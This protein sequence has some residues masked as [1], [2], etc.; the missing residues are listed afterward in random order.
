MDTSQNQA[1]GETTPPRTDEAFQDDIIGKCL[2]V[3]LRAAS[4]EQVT[5]LGEAMSLSLYFHQ[6]VS[7]VLARIERID[8]FALPALQD[9]LQAR[10]GAAFDVPR[11]TFRVGHREP[12]INAQPVGAHLTE[13]VYGQM[14]LLE[15]A[16][17]NFTLAE[18]EPGGQPRGNRLLNAREGR[19]R[20]PSAIEFAALCR[21]LDVGGRYQRHLDTVLQPAVQAG[22]PAQNVASLLAR[23]QRY[24][25]LVDAH[26]GRLKGVL[27]DSEH[28]ALVQLCHLRQPVRVDDCPVVAKQL[29]LLGCTLE[30]IVVL[31]V[32]DEGLLRN[33]SR[34]LLVHI[35]EDPQGAWSAFADLRH[36][37]ND[38]GK[39]LR[40]PE[41]QRFFSRFVR[42]RDSQR[43]F[44]CV[45]EGYEGVSD[46][47]NI[48]LQEHMHAYPAPLF[49]SLAAARIR[50]I[51]GDAAM[52]AVP[53]AEVDRQVQ[54][55]H[56]RRLAAE[57][58]TL[59]NLAG[60]F[61]PTLGAVLLAASAWSLLGEVFH[62]VKAWHEGDTSEALDH[63]MNVATDLAMIGG[64]AAGLG[65]ARRLW[66]RSA[67]VDDLVPARLEDGT[68]KLWNGDLAPF[69]S[70]APPPEA[71]ADAQGI[72][73]LGAQA[74]I[75]MDGQYYAVTQRAGASGTAEGPWQLCPQ[76]GHGPLLCHNGAGAWRLWSEQPLQWNDTYRMF[77]RLGGRFAELDDDRIDQVL[78]AHGMQVDHLRALHVQGRAPQAELVDS[79]MRAALDMRIS[80]L[81]SRL[82]AGEQVEGTALQHA[83]ALAGNA[84]HAG[85]TFA[86]LTWAQRRALF[87]RLYDGAEDSESLGVAALRRV[88]PSLHGRAAR[89]LL[90]TASAVDRQRLLD[91]GR[92]ALRLAEAARTSSLRIRVIRVYEALHLDTPQNADLARVAMGML[93]H[94]PGSHVGV[95]WRLFEGYADGPLLLSTEEGEQAFDLV[96]LNGK[97]QRLDVHGRAI[98]EPG[99]L[100]E[101]MA[102]AY[103]HR[104]REA[105][106][107]GEP[108]AHN[109]RVLLARQAV[110]RRPQVEKLLGRDQRAGAFRF[111]QRLADG[112]LGY[113]LSGR[114]PASGARTGRS[115]ALFSSVRE[116]YPTYSDAQVLAW[117]DDVQ[118]SGRQVESV[119][120]QLVQELDALTRSLEA[121]A[122]QASSER[123]RDERRYVHNTLLSCWQRR[124]TVGDPLNGPG[125]NIRLILYAA[126]PQIL[127]ELPAHVSFAHVSELVLLQMGL[128]SVPA[129]FL[130]AFSGLRLLDLGGN[131]LTRL[132]QGLLQM[133]Q[134]RELS[135]TNNRITLDAG[136]AATLASCESLEWINLS[137]NP[138]GRT[139]SL[140]GMRRLRMLNLRNTQISDL[141]Y[142]LLDSP[143]LT[144]ADLRNN[145]ITRLPES[146]YGAAAQ[147]RRGVML[148]GNPLAE[149]EALRLRFTLRDLDEQGAQG[150][151]QEVPIHPRELWADAVDPRYRGALI[152]RWDV[153]D[154]GERAERFLRVLRQLLQSADF[155]RNAR[156]MADRVLNLLLVM[157]EN[158]TLREE[159][160]A[161][162]NEEWGCQDGAA[163]CF[164]NLEVKVLVWRALNNAE[165]QPQQALLH[166]GR[167]LWRLD[168]VDRLVAQDIHTRSGHPDE[169]EVGLAY[170]LGLRES[171]DLPIETTDMS[172]GPLA[173]VSASR[174]AQVHAQILDN[175]TQE[176]L[177]QSL[178][179]REFWQTHL[180]RTHPE[181]F[182]RVDEPFQHR[183][184]VL[185]EDRSLPEDVQLQQSNLIR[186]AQRAAR[187]DLMIA[188]T[189]EALE[190]APEEPAI[191]VR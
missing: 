186:D 72:H 114:L 156:A 177:A 182:D 47:A 78:T 189:L 158:P 64:T 175:E 50:Q 110:Q 137:H 138:L 183:L 178:V 172:F 99:E 15:A 142:A 20:P 190:V 61:V 48:S 80:Q 98:D 25:M 102:A 141:P 97:F 170:R 130:D 131:R 45:I 103:H 89:E 43:F 53:V 6:Q 69:R 150:V 115:R 174:I 88:F 14:P 51:K 54:R 144:Q 126:R 116:V 7:A 127:P 139:F 135:L 41:Y 8:R 52:I 10:F 77:R 81:V 71:V 140:S 70:E 30:Q 40:T 122:G 147:L 152:S 184:A 96:H 59:L 113:P 35:P 73:R 112:R 165:G 134:L 12:I 101:V 36:F 28:R 27:S 82:R 107:I 2:P 3:W 91:S 167:Q 46:L 18:A 136:Q 34:R 109:L 60:L 111:P 65:V 90:R 55:E 180:E 92:V 164:S 106:G 181:R 188:L 1:L 23:A 67:V 21:E 4:V 143:L 108:F 42:R 163:W 68:T 49:E 95:R 93:E 104:Q 125:T 74:W 87:Q 145:L 154:V 187:H 123:V 118:R 39:R 17:R 121:W 119:L 32:I 100:F 57:G 31:D 176:R 173:G 191:A 166:L 129:S 148:S 120:H 56:D 44:A 19:V 132:P 124:T 63:L 168:E 79:V 75:E 128:H 169:S 58:R 160:F 13:V 29:S 5:A 146:F 157:A 94:L 24:G 22:E 83:R 151:D 171:L 66:S 37:A 149:E 155:Q 185:L 162:A 85:Q 84:A 161:V 16:L 86:E 11:W 159:L 62:G 105:M 33:T 26:I 9:A 117:A 76:G 133:A 153:V 38:L 179:D